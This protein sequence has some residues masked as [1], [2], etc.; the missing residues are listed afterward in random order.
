MIEGIYEAVHHDFFASRRLPNA[1]NRAHNYRCRF[2]FSIHIFSIQIQHT[3]IF[4]DLQEVTRARA[5][6]HTHTHTHTHKTLHRA[7]ATDA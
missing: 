7:E 2:S 4:F 6:A 5:R 1:H 3:I